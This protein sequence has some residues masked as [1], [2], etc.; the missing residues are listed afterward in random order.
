MSITANEMLDALERH[1]TRA[2]FI[3]E[4]E[5]VDEVEIARWEIEPMP[6]V[7]GPS[8]RRIDA[9]MIDGEQR[10]AVEVKTSWADYKNESDE[11]RRPWIALT[12]RFTYL[13]PVGVIPVDRIPEGLGLWEY[14]GSTIRVV[15]RCTVRSDVPPLP[16]YMIRNLLWRVSRL[17]QSKR[18]EKRKNALVQN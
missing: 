11:K 5:A 17:E 18:A 13:A 6:F 9:L 1:Y 15:R 2:A 4:L 8:L 16:D 14:D 10:T 7:A 12:H 3:R